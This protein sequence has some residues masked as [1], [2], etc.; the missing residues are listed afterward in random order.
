MELL[1]IAEGNAHPGPHRRKYKTASELKKDIQSLQQATPQASAAS[2]SSSGG[3]TTRIS[4]AH[5]TSRE[6][7]KSPAQMTDAYFLYTPSQIWFAALYLADRPLAEFYFDYKIGL[8]SEEDG[9]A[10]TSNDGAVAGDADANTDTDPLRP[11]R[12][13]ILQKIKS[14]AE[15]LSSYTADG[16]SSS[17]NNNTVERMKNL[18]RIGKKLYHCQNPEKVDIVGLNRAQKR[19]GGVTGVS[20]SGSGSASG[21][22]SGSGMPAGGEVFDAEGKGVDIPERAVKKRKVGEESGGGGGGATE[23]FGGELKG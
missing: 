3:I 9:S 17:N 22:A 18:K 15:L 21:S 12:S 16:S 8:P 10:N 6:L 11:L 20:G 7:L 23:V 2:S 5:H 14:C 19:D 4:K 13:L 1:A